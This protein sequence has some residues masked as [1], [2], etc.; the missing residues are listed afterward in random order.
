MLL[1]AAT[2]PAR[3]PSAMIGGTSREIGIEEEA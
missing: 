2:R 3:P 1:E